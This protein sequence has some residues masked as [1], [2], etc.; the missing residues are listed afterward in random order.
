VD[1]TKIKALLDKVERA[2]TQ[3]EAEAFAA[4]AQALMTKY[5]IDEAMLAQA[6]GQK[7]EI[8]NRDI[9]IAGTYFNADATLLDA[10]ARANSCRVL[11][12]K[13]RKKG[14]VIGFS[15]DVDRVLMTYY[16]L[17]TQ[18]AAAAKRLD[19]NGYEG[20]DKYVARRSFRHGFAAE[21]GRRLRDTR[22]VEVQE[23]TANPYA[24]ALR[25]KEEEVDSFVQAMNPGRARRS[26]QQFSHA[27]A[28]KGRAAAASADVGNPR[29]GG[30]K[31]SIT[32]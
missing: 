21:I 17:Q 32:S 22:D 8:V 9:Y 27:A 30:T 28:E 7:D 29:V 15:R 12:H 23:G 13:G 6:G 31:K 11:V 18:S 26:R 14:F 5:S 4:K 19:V 24:L 10:I 25:S 3:E 20:F 1:V 16:S 2:S